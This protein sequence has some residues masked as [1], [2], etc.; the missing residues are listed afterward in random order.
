MVSAGLEEL[1]IQKL[2]NMNI[3]DFRNFGTINLPVPVGGQPPPHLNIVYPVTTNIICYFTYTV[4][5]GNCQLNGTVMSIWRDGNAGGNL[6]FPNAINP[7]QNPCFEQI[8][9]NVTDL[10][11]TGNSIIRCEVVVFNF[12]GLRTSARFLMVIDGNL[13]A[14]REYAHVP[15]P[16]QTFL[17][18]WNVLRNP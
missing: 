9:Y 17:E 15:C 16:A 10:S 5:A 13:V 7:S 6:T 8:Q 18:E 14:E 11:T 1:K 12:P 2:T 3:T 4:E